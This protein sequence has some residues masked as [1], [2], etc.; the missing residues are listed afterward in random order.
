ME[1]KITE[2]YVVDR[3]IQYL[4]DKEN[5][6]WHEDKVKK[7]ELHQKGADIVMIGGE[8]YSEYFI[9][10]CKGKSCS[11]AAK[12]VNSEIWLNALGQI[13]TRMKVK[14][15]TRSRNDKNVITGV[16][17]AYKYGLGLYWVTAKSALRRIPKEIAKVLNLYIFSVY[18]DGT[19][20]M[21]PP[22]KIEE[23]YEEKDFK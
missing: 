11:P 1:K 2:E 7:A 5:G 9:I 23:E 6:N 19:V 13:V 8:K 18:D 15:I 14:R 16:N 21:F 20:K 12:S 10:E 17:R 3:V 22:S 4:L